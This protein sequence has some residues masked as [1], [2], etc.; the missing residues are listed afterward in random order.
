MQASNENR[1]ERACFTGGPL[2]ACSGTAGI[3]GRAGV[4]KREGE[5]ALRHSDDKTR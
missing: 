4:K 1:S 2:A 3:F 5:V